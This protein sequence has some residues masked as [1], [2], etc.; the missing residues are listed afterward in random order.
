M[1]F[2]RVGNKVISREKL[3][4]MITEILSERESGATQEQ[5]SAEDKEKIS[6]GNIQA[7]LVD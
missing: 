2:F 1:R 3:Y 4:E 7:L 6:S 5:K